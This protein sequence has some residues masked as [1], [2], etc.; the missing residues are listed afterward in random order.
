MTVMKFRHGHSLVA[1][2]SFID[3]SQFSEMGPIY[4]FSKSFI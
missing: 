2:F 1:D 4:D 3:Q